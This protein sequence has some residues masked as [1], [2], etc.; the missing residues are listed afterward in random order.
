MTLNDPI[1]IIHRYKNK[2]RKNQLLVYIFLGDLLSDEIIKILDK[3]KKLD[4]I[5]TINKLSKKDFKTMEDYYNDNWYNYFFISNHIESSINKIKNSFSLKKEIIDNR[6]KDWYEKHIDTNITPKKIKSFAAN[7]QELIEYTKRIKLTTK[8]EELDYRTYIDDLVG[9]HNII[10]LNIKGGSAISEAPMEVSTDIINQVDQKLETEEVEVISDDIISDNLSE[11]LNVEELS[12]LY[13]LENIQIDASVKETTKLIS[14]ALNDKSYQ[15]KSMKVEKEFNDDF[16]NQVYDAKLEETFNKNYIF[17]NYIYKNDTIKNMRNKITTSLPLNNKFKQNFLLPEYQY[18]YSKYKI[19]KKI[20]RIMIGQKW[21]RKNELLQIDIVP[22]DSLI[23]Y[24]NLK[25]NL[26][27]LRESFGFRLRREDDESSIINAYQDYITNNEIFMIDILNE[28]GI[29]YKNDAQ[30]IKNLFDV[31]VSIYFP[32]LSFEEFNN[33]LL[34]LQNK[35]KTEFIENNQNRFNTIKNDIM[36][37]NEIHYTVEE[38][39]ENI[40]SLNI[41][42]NVSKGVKLF[43]DNYILQSIIHVTVTDPKNITGTISS[44]KFNLYRIFDNFIVNQEFPFVEYQDIEGQITYKFYDKLNQDLEN[45]EFLNRWFENASQ[46]ITFR[47]RIKK[48]KFISITFAENGRIEYKITWREEDKAKTENIIESYE[49]IRT[50]LKKINDENRKVKIILPKNEKFQYAFVNTIQKFALPND[51]KINHNDLSDFARFFFPYVSLVIDPKK[52]VGKKGIEVESSKFGT[53]LR[54]KRIDKYESKSKMHIRILWYLKN[55]SISDKDLIDEIAKQFN[56]TQEDAAREI[57]DVKSKFSKVL[58]KSKSL[59]KKLKNLPKSKP[60]GIEIDVQGRE[61]NNY[62]VRITGARNKEQSMEIVEFMN[63]LIYL[64]GQTYILQKPKYQKIKETLKKLTNIAKRR[65]KVAELI[66]YEAD[67]KRVKV[68]TKL[69]KERLGFKPEEGQNQWSRSCQNS[70][71]DKRRQPNVIPGDK[72]NELIRNGYKLN[73]TNGF[74]EKE[75]NV[76]IKG[77]KQKVNIRA[78]KLG[79]ADGSSTGNF[80]TCDPVENGEHTFVGFLSKSNNPNDLCMPCCFKKDHLDTTNKKKQAYFMKCL[81]NESKDEKVEEE[82]IEKIKDKVYILQDTNKVI[83]GRFIYLSESLNRLFN[84]LWNNDYNIKNHYLIESNSG[85]FFKFTVRDNHY[86]FLAAIANIFDKSIKELIEI[87]VKNI[88]DNDILFT[89][90]N[91]GDIRG[92]FNNIKD[93]VH[94]LQNSRYLEYD[95]MGELL[96]HPN[97]LTKNGITYIILERKRGDDNYY[98]KCLNLENINNINDDRDIVI[99]TLEGKYYFPIYRL[100]KTK[101]EKVFNIQKYYDIDTQ[102]NLKQLFNELK[103]YFNTSCNNNLVK[104]LEPLSLLENKIILNKLSLSVNFKVKKQYIDSRYKCRYL[105]INY[106]KNNKSIIIPTK[107]TGIDYKL[108]IDNLNNMNKNNQ[109]LNLSD[110][111]DLLDIV[112]ILEKELNKNYKPKYLVYSSSKN[113]KFLIN[114]VEYQNNLSTPIVSTLLEQKEIDTLKKKYMI[115]IKFQSLEDDID[116]AINNNKKIDFDERLKNVKEHQYRSEGYNLFRLEL[117]NYLSN[118]NI[119]R[120]KIIEIVRSSLSKKEKRKELYKIVVNIINHKLDTKV[121]KIKTKPIGEIVKELPILSDYKK[122]NLR[123]ICNNTDKKKCEMNPHCILSNNECSFRLTIIMANDYIN[124]I[125]YEMVQDNISFKELIQEDEYFV[126]DIVDTT[127][128]TKRPSQVIVRSNNVNIRKILLDM[129]G[130]EKVPKIGKRKFQ[131]RFDNE[132]EE[133]PEMIELGSQYLQMIIPNKD[134]IIR[135]FVNCYYWM[136]NELYHN[137]ARNLGYFSD[138]QTQITNLLKAKMVEFIM[139][140]KESDIKEIREFITKNFPERNNFFETN[141]NNF[142]KKTANTNGDIELFILSHLI[143]HPIIVYNNFNQVIKIFNQGII[144]VNENNIQKYTS[145]ENIKNIIN[146][147]LEFEGSSKAPKNIFSV[148][149]I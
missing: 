125:L 27:Y 40:N 110:L 22:N 107:P 135:A 17:D 48:D 14:D 52:R 32:L 79:D 57:D 122:E 95:I 37:E 98:L 121:E 11:N 103:E 13:S 140:N 41:S 147:K 73:K 86:N 24:E 36:L 68:I 97:V 105:E 3:I 143:N 65:N 4:F 129:F 78:V 144:K 15:K 56:L 141:L 72:I 114:S 120:D 134:S 9:G 138:L 1:K 43:E 91:N 46:G 69:D 128:Y 145:K 118:D 38:A 61:V 19:D 133:Y 106:I 59:S 71:D 67:A 90:L 148:Y 137:N 116:N 16:E 113:G 102:K 89:Y 115:N 75:V 51:G 6:G 136:T 5:E 70:G 34:I 87:A 82:A 108:P 94:Y 42:Q 149:Y 53:Y 50:L 63:V 127:N 12:K 7:Y 99:M 26:S 21:T 81:G 117:S 44:D 88:K 31:Y 49:F 92:A 111:S 20:D 130:N 77:K 58:D 35:P 146:I 123:Y 100:S 112:L 60:P 131:K 104:K 96:G 85:Y 132:E 109:R 101:K 2:N 29:D 25:G 39:K 18:F 93:Y 83:E 23:P 142:R 62:K 30:K 66:D 47:M 10:K 124:R 33:L 8:T 45:Q 76:S 126:S 64:Y 139:L 28:L 80:Y 55:F 54:Y 84:K 119:T 74:Y